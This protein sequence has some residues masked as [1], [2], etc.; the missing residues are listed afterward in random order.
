MRVN[1]LTLLALHATTSAVLATPT[2][3]AAA[4]STEGAAVDQLADLAQSAFEQTQ[5]LVEDDLEK[6]DGTC[7]W[8]NIRIRR[9]W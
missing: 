6:R 4:A 3:S 9:E 2:G 5:E 7:T 1:C 8:Q